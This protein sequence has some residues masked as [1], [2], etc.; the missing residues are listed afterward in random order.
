MATAGEEWRRALTAEAD[1][2]LTRW[3]APALMVTWQMVTWQMALAA[4]RAWKWK[5]SAWRAC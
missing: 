4:R 5:S 1:M 3:I 2:R